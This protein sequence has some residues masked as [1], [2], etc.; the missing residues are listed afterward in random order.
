[1]HIWNER[2][3]VIEYI[4]MKKSVKNLHETCVV[5]IMSNIEFQYFII[6]RRSFR[7]SEEYPSGHAEWPIWYGWIVD[8]FACNWKWS[9][10][11]CTCSWSWFDNS[12]TESELYWVSVVLSFPLPLV[13]GSVFS[14]EIWYFFSKFLFDNKTAEDEVQFIKHIFVF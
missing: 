7:H 8:V 5:T 9:C 6:I 12:W 14:K 10:Y 2:I 3:L 4:M 11:S 13:I 1:M